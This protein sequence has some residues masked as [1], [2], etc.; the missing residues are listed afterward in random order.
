MGKNIV[1]VTTNKRDA[2]E[3]KDRI[4]ASL[5]SRGI[6]REAY[7]CEVSKAYVK[8]LTKKGHPIEEK[9]YAICIRNT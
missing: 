8:K 6:K 9:N 2:I 4:N 1:R 7:V 5:K 3:E